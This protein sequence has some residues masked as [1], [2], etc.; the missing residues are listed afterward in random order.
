MAATS[1]S[2]WKF[3]PKPSPYPSSNLFLLI[4][5]PQSISSNSSRAFRL[6]VSS[7]SSSSSQTIEIGTQENNP[8]KKKRKPRPSFL[9]KVQEKW[10]TK[11]TSS[12][13]ILP[14]QEEQ[15]NFEEILENCLQSD[16][17]IGAET[18]SGNCSELSGP[19]PIK[20]V[21]FPPWAHGNKQ[22]NSQFV[23]EANY[24]DESRNEVESIRGSN[25]VPHLNQLEEILDC[26]NEIGENGV[27]YDYIPIGLSKNG[28]NLVLEEDKVDKSNSNALEMFQESNSIKGFK[29]STRLPWEKQNERESVEGKRLRKSNA[30][31]AEKVIPEPE[32]KR[33]R[34]VALRMVERI[35]VGK[36]GVTQALV[37]SI[38]EKWK[39]D[40]VVK[41]KFEGPP[42]INMK[43]THEILEVSVLSH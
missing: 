37:D 10:S 4:F 41:L 12:R 17:V 22:R 40:E 7:F 43:R 25:V 20:K 8:T 13:E 2:P 15:V 1:P 18:N 34:N 11:T 38:H 35:K 24:L 21:N 36:A 16:G 33:L 19:A 31:L 28:Q 26:D 23:S 5:Q 3:L 42:S 9:D 39:L 14:W 32:L 6:R 30:D 29:D 27:E